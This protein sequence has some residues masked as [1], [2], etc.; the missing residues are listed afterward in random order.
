MVE[1]GLVKKGQFS[2][3][4]PCKLLYVL[5]LAKKKRV[6]MLLALNRNLSQP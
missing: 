5:S 2:R 6:F 1:A 3:T 4:G